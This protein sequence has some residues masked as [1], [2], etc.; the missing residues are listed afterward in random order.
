MVDVVKPNAGTTNDGNTVRIALSDKNRMV[1]S[2][3]L[4]LHQWLL[5]DFSNNFL[6]MLQNVGNFVKQL[7]PSMSQNIIGTQ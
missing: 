7:L 4:G 5:D 6:W 1:F 2:E 3:I